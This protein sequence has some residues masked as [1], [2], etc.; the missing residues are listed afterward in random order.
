MRTSLSAPELVMAG[1]QLVVLYIVNIVH[2][3]KLNCHVFVIGPH[4]IAVH[5]SP[6][7][8]RFQVVA[9]FVVV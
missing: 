3:K 6:D 8:L 4:F 2:T 7:T 1:A 9:P 5:L